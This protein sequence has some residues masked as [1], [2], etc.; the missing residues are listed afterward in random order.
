VPVAPRPK[1]RAMICVPAVEPAPAPPGQPL[2]RAR[3]IL[4]EHRI[5]GHQD[6]AAG[7]IEMV[8]EPPKIGFPPRSCYGLAP[9]SGSRYEITRAVA[10][11]VVIYKL[12]Q[13]ITAQHI[14]REA[15]IPLAQL[16][17]IGSV[18]RCEDPIAHVGSRS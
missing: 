11:L 2:D 10:E 13:T 12:D 4:V 5:A 16:E 17:D 7:K 18:D 14:K 9:T 6:T 8:H 15:T 1:P 3:H